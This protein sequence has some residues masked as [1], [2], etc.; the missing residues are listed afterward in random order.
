MN[1]LK[2]CN[3]IPIQRITY[4]LRILKSGSIV[5]EADQFDPEITYTLRILKTASIVKEADQF[6]Q[7]FQHLT[8]KRRR[9]ISLEDIDLILSDIYF[10][11]Y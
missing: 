8:T 10:I 2:D 5:K 1:I 9:A 7:D 3:S 11:L 4:T 6:A